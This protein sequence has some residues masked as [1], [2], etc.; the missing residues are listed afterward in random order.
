VSVAAKSETVAN[1]AD[2]SSEKDLKSAIAF[3]QNA[4]SNYLERKPPNALQQ[5]IPGYTVMFAFLVAGFMA[6]WSIEEKRNGILRRLRSSPVSTTHLL[7]GKLFY[8]LAICLVQV[9]VLFW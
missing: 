8:G 7:S 6:G 3:T 1:A 2:K 5:A 4:P 9:L